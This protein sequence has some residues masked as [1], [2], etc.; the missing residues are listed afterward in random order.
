MNITILIVTVLILAFLTCIII[1]VVYPNLK[2]Y[3]DLKDRKT[4]NE[5]FNLYSNID[6]DSVQQTIDNLID[7]KIQEYILYRIRI[8]EN[9]YINSK[10]SENM[11]ATITESIYIEL[12]ELYLFYIKLLVNVETDEDVLSF[13]NSRVKYRA[14]LFISDNNKIT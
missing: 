1:F 2:R 5:L 7:G 3:M 12:S 6:P 11:I 10:D 14:I 9:Q 13:I 8:R 4:K